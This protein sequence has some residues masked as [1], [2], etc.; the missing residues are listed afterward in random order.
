MAGK[1]FMSNLQDTTRKRRAN[2]IFREVTETGLL[3]QC[4]YRLLPPS[5]MCLTS[6]PASYITFESAA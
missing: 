4:Q 1:K 2:S 5:A 3:Q 6:G